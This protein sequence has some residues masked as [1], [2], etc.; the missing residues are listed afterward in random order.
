MPQVNVMFTGVHAPRRVIRGLIPHLVQPYTGVTAVR[1][2]HRAQSS[3]EEETAR[4]RTDDGSEKAAQPLGLSL[5]KQVRKAKRAG[6]SCEGVKAAAIL[7]GQGLRPARQNT[8][9][10]LNVSAT[11]FCP[12]FL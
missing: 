4:R 6:M 9:L 11:A 5:L 12:P 8:T 2:Y 3:R 10:S 1:P 7:A